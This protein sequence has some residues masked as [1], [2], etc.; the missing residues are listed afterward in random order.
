MQGTILRDKNISV[1]VS[2]LKLMIYT[3]FRQFMTGYQELGFSY[4]KQPQ[5]LVFHG[6]LSAVALFF[7]E[8]RQFSEMQTDRL[9]FN[10]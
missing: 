8:N 10:L 7:G 5:S 6:F 3:P 4:L 9:V 1:F 2:I